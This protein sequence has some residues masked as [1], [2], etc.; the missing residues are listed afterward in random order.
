MKNKDKERGI[1]V[2]ANPKETFCYLCGKKNR[3]LKSVCVYG[4]RK[5]YHLKC[6]FSWAEERLKVV[7]EQLK[8]LKR[9]KNYMILEE[10]Q[11]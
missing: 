6:Y 11:L 9:Y 4:K 10:L 2:I 1:K 5:T 8:Y 3:G 7:R